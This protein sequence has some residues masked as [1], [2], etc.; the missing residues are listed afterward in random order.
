MEAFGTRRLGK[1]AA[2]TRTVQSKIMKGDG[3]EQEGGR[4]EGQRLELCHSYPSAILGFIF[5]CFPEIL[6]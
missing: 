4:T 3:E 1:R 5:P 6:P 2:V